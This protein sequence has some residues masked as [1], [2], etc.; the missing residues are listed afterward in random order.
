MERRT[1]FVPSFSYFRRE[2]YG[3][4]TN[5]EDVFEISKEVHQGSWDPYEFE[6]RKGVSGD[7]VLSCSIAIYLG[8][9]GS[10]GEFPD[11]RFS[12]CII[13]CPHVGKRW[14][15]SIDVGIDPSMRAAM[16]IRIRNCFGR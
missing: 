7:R 10:L 5:T 14:V 6:R 3:N 16:E 13:G 2:I 12:N 11:S 1:I 8:P 4:G 15:A 9:L